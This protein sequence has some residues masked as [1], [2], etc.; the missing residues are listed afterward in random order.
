MPNKSWG[1]LNSV[2]RMLREAFPAGMTEG[3]KVKVSIEFINGF[4][5]FNT[6]P[7][8]N[9]EAWSDGYRIQVYDHGKRVVRVEAEDLD[10]ALALAIKQAKCEHSF[11]SN[12]HNGP[13][14]AKGVY[15]FCQHCGIHHKIAQG[16][17][18]AR[19]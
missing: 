5:L 4:E 7:Y 14:I 8:H 12:G 6:R 17:K 18:L 10:E 13:E 3:V 15:C 1:A 16:E 11:A 19:E 2:D 9:Y